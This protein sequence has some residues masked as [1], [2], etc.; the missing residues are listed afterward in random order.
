MIKVVG[1]FKDRKGHGSCSKEF[2]VCSPEG[3][4]KTDS[5]MNE[6]AHFMCA[7]VVSCSVMYVC[8]EEQWNALFA[9]RCLREDLGKPNLMEGEI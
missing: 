6:R 2:R 3:C 9:H 8:L 4:K 1:N 7:F 5:K